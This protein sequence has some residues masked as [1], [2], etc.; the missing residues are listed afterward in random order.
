[1]S[2]LT[3]VRPEDFTPDGL[4]GHAEVLDG[5]AAGLSL[6]AEKFK[7][8]EDCVALVCL[9]EDCLRFAAVFRGLADVTT[10]VATACGIIEAA[11]ARL[12][13][14]DGPVGDA[15]PPMTISEWQELYETLDRARGGG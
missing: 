3:D 10:A 1:V 4:R 9:S 15:T 12:L 7:G 13:A 2:A 14:L 6:E 8:G 5:L 11:D